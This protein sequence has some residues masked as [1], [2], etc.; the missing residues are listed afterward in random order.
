[1]ELLGV[2]F[3]WVHFELWREGSAIFEN[4]E[5][6]LTYGTRLEDQV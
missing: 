3:Y 4:R 1:M 2:S 6:K 5:K